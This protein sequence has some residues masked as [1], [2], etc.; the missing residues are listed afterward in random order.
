VTLDQVNAVRQRVIAGEEV[1]MEELKNCIDALRLSR[2]AAPAAKKEKAPAAKSDKK[3][4]ILTLL[5]G[6]K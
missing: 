5:E 2:S 6:L 1:S 4:A 3:A